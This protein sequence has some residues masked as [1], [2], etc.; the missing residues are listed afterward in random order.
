M[1][2][3]WMIWAL[4]TTIWFAGNPSAAH[5][6]IPMSMSKK[7]HVELETGGSI[8]IN[9][10]NKEEV[11]LDVTDDR[12]IDSKYKIDVRESREG[13]TVHSYLTGDESD[14]KFSPGLHMMVPNKTNIELDLKDGPITIGGVEG[15]VSGKTRDGDVKLT[16][17]K[18][19]VG[20]S[21]KNGDITLLKSDVDGELKSRGGNVRLEDVRGNVKGYAMAGSVKYRNVKDWNGN[22]VGDPVTISTFGGAISVDDA[23]FGADVRTMGSD[24]TIGS[25]TKFVKASTMGG[26]INLRSVDGWVE[27]QTV[28]GNIDV[29]L[30]GDPSQGD[31]HATLKTDGGSVSLVIPDELSAMIN[32][33]V[34]STGQKEDNFGIESDFPLHQEESK[35]LDPKTGKLRTHIHG[36]AQIASGKNQIHI[37]VTDGDVVL[38]KR[39]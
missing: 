9:G 31:K 19:S 1:K 20:F 17:L 39:K 32:V 35:D 34:T 7:L 23:R 30:V 27:A 18:G 26:C 36:T 4:S 24:I 38:K 5:R 25:A 37:E 13:L 15:K 28:G 11:T 33:H 10:W 22:D 12:G 2:P 29:V 8:T 6:E 14:S 16:E 21:T 3:P